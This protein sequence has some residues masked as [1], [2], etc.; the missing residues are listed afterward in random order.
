[1][2]AQLV[3]YDKACRAVAEALSV[4]EANG[5]R[6]EA[7]GWEAYARQAK[8]RRMLADAID[9]KDRATRRIGELIKAQRAAVGLAKGGGDHRVQRGPGALPTLEA[10]GIDKHLANRAR[11]YVRMPAERFDELMQARRAAIEL[12]AKRISLDLVPSLV[13]GTQGTG[14]NEW[15]T[16]VEYIARARLVLGEIDLDPA[17]TPQANARVKATQIFTEVDNGLLQS[18]LGN[19]W[20]N[21][22]YAQPAIQH[23]AD[24]MVDELAA[25]HVTAA[26]ML[27][28]NYT[29]TAWFQQLA[30]AASAICFTRGRIRFEAPNGDLAAPTQG[31]AFFYFGRDVEPFA[32][33]FADVGF[34]VNVVPARV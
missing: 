1:M 23:F 10:A 20:L 33:V 29:D 25:G 3:R 21:P 4:V 16:P 13:R 5:I 24:K 11:K 26:I 18:W 15:Y 2:D 32:V 22:P 30:H 7:A 9:I 27:T 14:D 31:Q 6:A 28:H 17:S 8:N 12:E 34:V 19:V